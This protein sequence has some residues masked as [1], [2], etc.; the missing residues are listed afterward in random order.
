[1][2]QEGSNYE[3][4]IDIKNEDVLAQRIKLKKPSSIFCKV[5]MTE[6]GPIALGMIRKVKVLLKAAPEII[7]KFTD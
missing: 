4:K 6:M 5:Q 2:V 1:V 7:G 3:L